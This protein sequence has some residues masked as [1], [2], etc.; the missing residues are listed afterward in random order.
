MELHYNPLIQ[1]DLKL[2]EVRLFWKL[3]TKRRE[4]PSAVVDESMVT[5]QN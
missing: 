2:V 5:E 3:Q 4:K 1:E